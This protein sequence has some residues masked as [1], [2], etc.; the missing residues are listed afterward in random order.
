MRDIFSLYNLIGVCIALAVLLIT[1][2]VTNHF[3]RLNIT[4][5]QQRRNAIDKAYL[6]WYSGD[7]RPGQVYDHRK[8]KYQLV[9]ITNTLCDDKYAWPLM[10]TYCDIRLMCW[11]TRP[12]HEFLRSRTL[13]RSVDNE[14][15]DSMFELM[16]MANQRIDP[17]KE[18]E[19]YPQVGSQ[20]FYE[21]ETSIHTQRDDITVTS[22]Y[23][24]G[25][26]QPI[27]AYYN[28]RTPSVPEAVNLF[29][30]LKKYRRLEQE[31]V[32]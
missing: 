32:A 26:A 31:K 21:Q 16:A 24:K 19:R 11:Y 8:G 1:L 2:V 4:R 5:E 10:A 3:K 27:V 22:V 12:L 20:W 6:D 28:V 30:F 29:Q 7:V 18:E 9:L 17:Q 15:P 13:D 14:L 23:N 25:R